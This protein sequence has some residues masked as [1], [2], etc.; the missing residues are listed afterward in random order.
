M[1]HRNDGGYVWDDIK[2]LYIFV[3]AGDV[4]SD[5]AN[6]GVVVFY[7]RKTDKV[8]VRRFRTYSEILET[9]WWKGCVFSGT[10]SDFAKSVPRDSALCRVLHTKFNEW[11]A[12]GKPNWESG[13]LEHVYDITCELHTC[14]KVRRPQL[15]NAQDSKARFPDEFRDVPTGE[16]ARQLPVGTQVFVSKG[17]GLRKCEITQVTNESYIGRC[18]GNASLLDTRNM[19]GL[20]AFKWFH[21]FKIV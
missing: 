4:T 16:H 18:H 21:V 6:R 10:T 13:S 12:A 19:I 2:G 14:P 15:V 1:D 7:D 3:V 11:L 20:I 9:I 17:S 5:G 8:G